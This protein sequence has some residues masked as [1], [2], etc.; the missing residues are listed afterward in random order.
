MFYALSENGQAFQDQVSIYIA[1]AP[2]TKI[3]NNTVP[4]LDFV[5]Y[6]YDFFDTTTQDLGIYEILGSNWVTKSIG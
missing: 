4:G 3:T 1:L 2:I 6:N 5:I